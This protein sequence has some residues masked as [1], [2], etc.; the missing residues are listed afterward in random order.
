MGAEAVTTHRPS[1]DDRTRIDIATGCL[2]W[3]GAKRGDGYGA[4]HVP[5]RGQVGAHRYAWERASGT[6]VPFGAVVMHTCDTPL[7]VNANHLTVG[8]PAEN[9][10][11]AD[12]K[13]RAAFGVRH[14]R[15]LL[16][17]AQVTS[18]RA[19]RHAGM[20]QVEIAKRYRISLSQARNIYMGI[21][22]RHLK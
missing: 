9:R 17:E 5:A 14:G 12:K 7:C 1:F 21:Q 22:W 20:S 18:L 16:T 6:P 13:R 3:T 11:D 4:Y 19:D 15:C 8:S 10:H 2:L